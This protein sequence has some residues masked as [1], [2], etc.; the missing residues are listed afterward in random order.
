MVHAKTL[1]NP[2]LPDPKCE[3][4]RLSRYSVE[5]S[6]PRSVRVLKIQL[7]L[8][9]AAELIVAYMEINFVSRNSCQKV[10]TKHCVCPLSPN[11]CVEV[12]ET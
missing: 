9:A 10:K 3:R 12:A 2:G 4:V 1:E 8:E 6:F 7:E 5:G 11:C